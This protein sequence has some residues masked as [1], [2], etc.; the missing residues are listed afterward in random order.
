MV[1]G[2]TGLLG[3]VLVEH[4]AP[5]V[6]SVV[7]TSRQAL[8]PIEDWQA[9][10]LP[11]VSVVEGVD[12][13]DW[14]AVER[15]LDERRPDAVLNATGVTPRR[16]SIHDPRWVVAVNS[17][18]PHQLAG[19]CAANGARLVTISTDCVFDTEPGGFVESDP[20]TATDLYGRSKA[21]GEVTGSGAVT[22]RTSF[23]GRELVGHTELL[24]WFLAQRGS[25]IGGYT[26]VW[27]SGLSVRV[28]ARVLTT[29][30]L[31]RRD[32][33][34]VRHLA[35]DVPI[36]K[37]DLLRLANEAFD[38]GVTIEPNPSV[39]SR[40]TLDGTRLRD[41]LGLEQPSWQAMLEEL[42]GDHRYAG[43]SAA[44]AA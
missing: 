8:G 6:D 33:V 44:G 31:D 32:V 11:G 40:R 23:I 26:D 21:L 42:A 38:A 43:W 19:W 13:R 18:A 3:H 25:T 27:Y 1:L 5:R 29:L 37:F 7:A 41:E 36:S 10:S 2:A 28:V 14:P 9:F 30:A 34:G 20:T 24:D 12:L 4:L 17:L 35:N 39:R 15:L 22:L 16:D